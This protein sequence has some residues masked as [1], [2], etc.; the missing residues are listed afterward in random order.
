[1]TRLYLKFTIISILLLFSCNAYGDVGYK[2]KALERF[3]KEVVN[4][5]NHRSHLK[6]I[7]VLNFVG[8]GDED[9]VKQTLMSAIT[10]KTN[11]H[12]VE[13]KEVEKFLG[14][15]DDSVQV[16]IAK[17]LKQSH[18]MINGVDGILSGEVHKIQESF[19]LSQ[20]RV[21][22]KLDNIE[23]G[24]VVFSGDYIIS[25]VSS[26]KNLVMFIGIGLIVLVVVVTV[27]AKKRYWFHEEQYV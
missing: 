15:N 9:V 11:V 20:T 22:L 27:I 19:W 16:M 8:A 4:D 17:L 24:E 7:C 18:S 2:K 3:Q 23:N 6:R 5:L 13:L 12:V 25:S 1:M 21:Y 14:E 26:V 10:D